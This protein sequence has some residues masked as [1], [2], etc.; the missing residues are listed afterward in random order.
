MC[1]LYVK[2]VADGETLECAEQRAR[3]WHRRRDTDT[4][5]ERVRRKE[6]S[7]ADRG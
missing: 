7:R 4:A 6:Q 5:G 1:N 3:E 2:T